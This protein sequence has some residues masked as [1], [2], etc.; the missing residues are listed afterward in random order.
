ME[1][2]KLPEDSAKCLYNDKKDYVHVYVSVSRL[3]KCPY[4]HITIA[5]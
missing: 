4:R 1:L 5:E 3:R 2:S